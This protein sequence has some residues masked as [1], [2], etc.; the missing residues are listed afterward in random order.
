MRSAVLG[1]ALLALTQAS[2]VYADDVVR[3]LSDRT[4]SHLAPMFAAFTK[5]TG[6]QVESVFM[7]Q[8]LIDRVAGN[9]GEADVV[10]TKDAELMEIAREKGLL[11]PFRSDS[12]A[13]EIDR[14]FLG[15]D[16][17]YFVDAYR[18]RVIFYSKARVKAA[19]LSTY[20]DLAS[21]KWR[22][23]FCIRSGY[24]DYNLALFSQM[25]VAYGQAKA[26]SIVQGL[27]DN[28]AREP[29]GNDR[30][31]AKAI[32]EGKCDLALMNTYYHPIMMDNPDQRPWAESIGVFYPDQSGDGAFIMRSA[33]GLTKATRNVAG[34]TK[35]LEFFAGRNGQ[36]LLANITYQYPTNVNVPLSPRLSTLGAEQPSV[37][38]GQFK[39]N[40]VPLIAASTE[41]ESVVKTL[42]ETHFDKR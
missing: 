7:D 1:V 10:I 23:R 22:G 36:T 38:G 24:H 17:A 37:K 9:L 35:L 42:N 33:L 28:L 15:P 14:K 11:Q 39:M 29:K 20:A 19:D 31:Q 16:A 18:A 4:E 26:R 32:F 27:H 30:E 21:P 5:S 13:K 34:A 2:L 25:N 41:R 40:F 12:I 8:G 6:I 3:V